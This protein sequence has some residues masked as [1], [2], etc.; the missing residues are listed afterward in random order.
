MLTQAGRR[1]LW[2]T[3]TGYAATHCMNCEAGWVRAGK[4][5]AV[6][7][8]L[9]DREPVLADMTSCNRFEP[10]EAQAAAA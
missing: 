3:P 7:M 6:V 4:E 1:L 10:K 8:C 2:Q 5:G 9:L